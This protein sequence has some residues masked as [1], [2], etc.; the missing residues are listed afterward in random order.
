MKYF[1]LMRKE[2]DK[3]KQKNQEEE[4]EDITTNHINSFVL[5]DPEAKKKDISKE[6]LAFLSDN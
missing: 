3:T 1:F 5:G 2:D 6:N 4:E